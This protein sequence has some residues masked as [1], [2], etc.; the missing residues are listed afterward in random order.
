MG[1][2]LHDNLPSGLSPQGRLL[3]V[4][5]LCQ[6]QRQTFLSE[7]QNRSAKELRLLLWPRKECGIRNSSPATRQDIDTDAL[8]IPAYLLLLPAKVL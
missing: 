8:P 1:Y 3:S 5:Q 2:A 6:R 4:H 7:L